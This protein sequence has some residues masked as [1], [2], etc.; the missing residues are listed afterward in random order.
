VVPVD[1]QL[2]DIAAALDL[3]LPAPVLACGPP[4]FDAIVARAHRRQFRIER[5]GIDNGLA[6][7]PPLLLQGGVELGR[8]LAGIN[9]GRGG[10]HL[11]HQEG[12]PASQVS[13]RCTVY[14]PHWVVCCRAAWASGA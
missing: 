2:T 8:H 4:A 1:H 3:G 5:A 14:P 10:F 12:N 6:R 11:R 13:G 9:R 7:Q